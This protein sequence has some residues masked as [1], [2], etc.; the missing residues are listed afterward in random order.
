MAEISWTQ[1]RKSGTSAAPN[2]LWS[3]LP[4]QYFN[5]EDWL[6]FGLALL[7]VLTVAYG[8]ESSHWSGHMPALVLVSVLGLSTSMLLAKSRMSIFAAW[9]LAV[10]L[11]ALVT[12][13]QTLDAVGPGTLEA[14]FHA[15]YD[16]FNTWFDV[17]FSNG[18]SNDSLPFNTLVVAVTWLAT[19]VFGWSVF[20]W[21]HAWIGLLPGGAALFIGLVFVSDSL[22]T[23]IALYMLVG[24]LLI[25][26]TN[27]TKRMA[28]WRAT[29]V[30]YPPLLSLSFM[31]LTTWVLLGLL[32]AAWIVPVG[33]Y[34]TPGAVDAVVSR[35]GG[36]GIDFVRLAGPLHVSKVV[37]V[38][39]YRGVLPLQGSVDLGERELLL[40]ELKDRTIQGPI[41]LRG[42][43][44][45][46][47]G[48]GGWT[49]GDRTELEVPSAVGERL[50]AALEQGIDDEEIDGRLVPLEI[51]LEA[52]SVV[53]TV[54]F[55][56]GQAVGSD[57]AV[58]IEVPDGSLVKIEPRDD[59]LRS[60]TQL[61]DDEVIERFVPIGFVGTSVERDES[62]AVVSILGFESSEQLLPDIESLSPDSRVRRGSS[63]T[64]TG[65]VPTVTAE[66]LRAADT[67]Y[68]E[69]V[70]E[71]YLAL[72][73]S[74]PFRVKDLSRRTALDADTPYDK[75]LAIEEF[76]RN[77]YTVNY[78][79]G[80][81]PPGEDTIDHFLFESRTGF[82]D[83]HAS[84]MALMLR[85]VNVPSRLAVGFV[86]DETDF[87]GI[88]SY[89]VRDKNS[90]SW[91]EVYFP[92]YGWIP[93][94]PS[95]DRPADLTP[96]ERTG[97]T[98]DLNGDGVIDIRDFPGLPITSDPI[99]GLGEE[100]GFSSPIDSVPSATSGGGSNAA[101][102]SRWLLAAA[103]VVAVMIAGSAALGWRRSMVG[104]PFAQATW[105]KTVR[106]ASLAG[107]GPKPGQTPDEFTQELQR[108]FRGHRVIGQIG[109]AYT[110]SRFGRT[111][112][113][114]RDRASIEDQWPHLRT[115]FI[116]RMVS[117][118]L[119]RHNPPPAD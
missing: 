88:G 2:S 101:S 18:V 30:S 74:L 58:K 115:A 76:L 10:F 53:G 48:S 99:F 25:M 109:D 52:K 24:F 108:T 102:Y 71:N 59:M 19:F 119:R 43:V 63:Y 95:P 50:S 27:L 80:E 98:G 44:Y 112:I 11:G 94:N 93:F 116:G 87:D 97:G 35:F 42:T 47:Y 41:A 68:P 81:P 12:L 83:Y 51:T 3:R 89:L 82:F 45:E 78:S 56:P 114:E 79:P 57:P 84:A 107:H 103:A 66:D 1:S 29:K 17:A 61:T 23:A 37:P 110:R 100:E 39:S 14:R 85:A 60:G 31:H 91:T 75:A 20:R 96:T 5:W 65:F 8:L 40:V 26:R 72:P 22:A 118:L 62:G 13:W 73:D 38:H 49:T 33:P 92:G 90:Y 104:L 117:R 113:G 32:V 70:S 6:T 105:E 77:N 67:E 55:S 86:V 4:Q 36:V 106:L 28:E 34:A 46:D 16:R 7:A 9:P 15:I 111:E 54:L 69:W 64:V 21:H